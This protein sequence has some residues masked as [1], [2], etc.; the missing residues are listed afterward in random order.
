M[1]TAK[2]LIGFN[3]NLTGALGKRTK[4]QERAL[5]QLRVET[6]I[7]E[8]I[9]DNT[10]LE[11][12]PQTIDLNDDTLLEKISFEDKNV[13]NS[14]TNLT[15]PFLLHTAALKLKDNVLEEMLREEVIAFLE[16]II[17]GKTFS[18]CIATHAYFLRSRLEKTSI[19][20][21]SRCMEQLVQPLRSTP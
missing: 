17:E 9:T 8:N 6:I 4:Y 13:Q 19:R 15:A 21:L 10:P 2:K 12:E 1:E 7:E 14:V 3:F 20:R 18:Y 16:G 11:N 5:P